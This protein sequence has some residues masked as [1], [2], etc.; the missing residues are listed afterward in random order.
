MCLLFMLLLQV[1]GE[2]KHTTGIFHH[3]VLE[4]EPKIFVIT[5]IYLNAIKG[6]FSIKICTSILLPY[7]NE[8]M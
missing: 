4:N 7:F 8:I 3:I 1:L 5:N 6:G 2:K